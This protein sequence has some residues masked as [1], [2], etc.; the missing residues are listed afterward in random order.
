VIVGPMPTDG[1]PAA[2]TE[3]ARERASVPGPMID[4]Y[5]TVS[6]LGAGAMGRVWL[7]IDPELDRRVAIKLLRKHDASDLDLRLRREAQALAR[8]AH[9]NVAAIYDVGEVDGSLFLAMEYVGGGTLSAWMR[10]AHPWRDV[11][12]VFAG[13]GRGLAAVHARG[14]VH[15]D[16]KPDNVLLDDTGGAKVTDFGLVATHDEAAP[17]ALGSAEGMDVFGSLT[18]TGAILGTPAYMAPEQLEGAPADARSDQF[19]YC[20]AFYEALYGVRPFSGATVGQLRAALSQPPPEP[21]AALRKKVPRWLHDV[22]RRGLAR[23]P[24]RRFPSMDA[25]VGALAGGDRR[26]RRAIAGA[27]LGGVLVAGGAAL[28]LARGGESA[29][30]DDGGREIGAVWTPARRAEVTGALAKASAAYGGEMSAGVARVL[31]DYARRWTESR[32]RVCEDERHRAQPAAV[33]AARQG[34]LARRRGELATFV[35]V[36]ASAT[37]VLAERALDAAAGL[38]AL[39]ECDDIA[40]LTSIVPPPAELRAQIEAV[41]ADLVRVDLHVDSGMLALAAPVAEKA[42][43]VASELGYAPLAAEALVARGTVEDARS[44]F[45]ASIATYQLA[46][47]AADRGRDDRTRFRALAHAIDAHT[48]SA[49][50][51]AAEALIP[52][53]EA[54]LS[55]AENDATLAEIWDI[56]RSRVHYMRG[57]V[58]EARALQDEAIARA[59]AR[60]DQHA[61][62]EL[63][64][65]AVLGTMDVSDPAVSLAL[66]E[67]SLAIA[68]KEYGPAHPEVARREQTVARALFLQGQVDDARVRTEHARD[69]LVATYG[70]KHR[71]V[72]SVK[73]TLGSMYRSMDRLDESRALTEDALATIRELLGADHYWAADALMNLAHVERRAGKPDVALGYAQQARDILV[74][75]LGPGTDGLV[76]AYHAIGMI[77]RDLGHADAAEKAYLDGAAAGEKNAP[78][79]PRL[80]LFYAE[81]G[82][83][84]L[85][86]KDAAG[87]VQYLSKALA[88]FR[89]GSPEY[90]A[91]MKLDLAHAKEQLGQWSEVLV[92]ATEAKAL[93]SDPPDLAEA[94]ALI[95]A[96]RRHTKG[97][98]A[99]TAPASKDRP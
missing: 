15:R 43:A 22:V 68:T 4:R 86:R 76:A 28:V 7:A 91:Y 88:T 81:L 24:G 80:A 78:D 63:L 48:G 64:R 57:R 99:P 61:L 37:P 8:L 34:C 96:A 6:E 17:F 44:D 38:P 51:D 42:V 84:R 33:T 56:T 65:H 94:E 13:A 73:M 52:A 9:P 23:E 35:E 85:E 31:D 49:N 79:N 25:L 59:R 53:A 70:D 90:V 54:A 62:G 72:A 87:A 45:A 60:G 55:R 20:V 2:V 32:T 12:R 83:I 30:C 92:L 26:R 50:L 11:V 14:L 21:S 3:P 71:D 1:D 75:N 5:V 27:V 77:E 66:A 29:A 16:F 40:A 89:N 58:A 67:E 10:D 46:A 19:S 93:L 69:Q 74:K 41:R 95:R 98:T 18:V 39:G 47:A 36:L 82:S 97:E